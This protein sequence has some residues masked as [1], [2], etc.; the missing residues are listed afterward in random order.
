[1]KREAIVQGISS[2]YCFKS[3][4]LTSQQV[5]LKVECLHY[6]QPWSNSELQ[7]TVQSYYSDRVQN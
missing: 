6:T 4:S 3:G 5:K 2:R 7:S 1:M